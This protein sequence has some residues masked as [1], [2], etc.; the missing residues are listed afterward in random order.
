MSIIA[1]RGYS[2]RTKRLI[3]YPFTDSQKQESIINS[4]IT[5]AFVHIFPQKQYSLGDTA[6]KIAKKLQSQMVFPNVDGKGR[7]T[8]QWV[9]E[10]Y[11][12]LMA[13]QNEDYVKWCNKASDDKELSDFRT[14][15]NLYSGAGIEWGG[16]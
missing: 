8:P 14:R 6:L 2:T 15:M 16:V 11:R 9:E 10:R 7:Y 13:S 4:V 5:I 12:Q 3:P 1:N